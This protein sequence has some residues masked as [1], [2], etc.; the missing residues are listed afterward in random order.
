MT[1]VCEICGKEFITTNDH[2]KYCGDECAHRAQLQK[3]KDFRDRNKAQKL[4]DGICDFCRKSFIFKGHGQHFCSAEC[5]TK[6][7]K[8]PTIHFVLGGPNGEVIDTTSIKKFVEEHSESFGS[9]RSAY[10]VLSNVKL[11]RHMGWELIRKYDENG[12]EW[13]IRKTS[14]ETVNSGGR[15]NISGN[16]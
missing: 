12:K 7:Y 3:V 14:A 2:R 8:P 13:E 10:V 1:K 5:R 16:R 9:T 11:G 4:S 15:K 6:Y